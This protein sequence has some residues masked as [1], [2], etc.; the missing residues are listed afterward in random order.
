MYLRVMNNK[1]PF[2]NKYFILN[3]SDEVSDIKY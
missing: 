3:S 2:H 1:L